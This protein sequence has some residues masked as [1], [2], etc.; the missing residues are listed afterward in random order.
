MANSN[1][2]TWTQLLHKSRN[3]HNF[4]QTM[5]VVIK[6]LER[7]QAG[8]TIDNIKKSFIDEQE[9]QHKYTWRYY[10]AQYPGML[11]GADG[12]LTWDATNDYIC[13]TLNKHQFNGQHWNSFLNVVYQELIEK[14]KLE[15]LDKVLIPDNY[16]GNLK[17][18][19]PISSIASVGYVY[20]Y[21]E[22]EEHWPINQV[23][24]VDAEDRVIWAINRIENI[25]QLSF[26]EQSVS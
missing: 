15:N 9:K 16:G 23:D 22:D 13:T 6:L 3:R 11:R 17:L 21:Q 5:S 8:E 7:V 14:L 18:S 12:E 20:Y 4:E 19:Q 10:F 2:S 25:I 1:R 26:N 24:G